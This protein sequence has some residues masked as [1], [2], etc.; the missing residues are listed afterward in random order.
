MDKK[1]QPPP[2]PPQG[3]EGGGAVRGEVTY[4]R[5]W[6]AGEVGARRRKVDLRGICK[7]NKRKERVARNRWNYIK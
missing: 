2:P 1:G 3:G 4:E 6:G 7:E 5:V